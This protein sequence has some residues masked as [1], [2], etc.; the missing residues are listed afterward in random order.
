[1]RLEAGG[2]LERARV[3]LPFFGNSPAGALW[4]AF[5][6]RVKGVTLTILSSGASGGWEHVS[7]SAFRTPTWEEM[8]FVKALFWED[9]EVV[10]QLHPRASEYVNNHPHCLHLWRAIAPTP[11]IP[12]PPS[13]YVGVKGVPGA[14]AAE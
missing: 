6:Y 12:E 11:P 7:V 13:I 9:E 3:A 14:V 5:R 4:G 1:M 2:V 10:M 8:C